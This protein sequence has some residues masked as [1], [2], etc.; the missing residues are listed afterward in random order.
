ME[1]TGSL[2]AGAFTTDTVVTVTVGSDS[3]P[4][5]EGDDYATVAALQFT[6]AAGATSGQTTFTLTPVDDAIS[7][8]TEDIQVTGTAS[9]LGVSPTALQ[10]HDNDTAST[11]L[12][13]SLLPERVSE[14]LPEDITVTAT[15]DAGALDAD[16]AIEL[17]VGG[18]SDTGLPGEDYEAVSEWTLTILA[19][20]TSASTVFR[21]IPVDNQVADEART[22]SVI[23]STTVATLSVVP[24]DGAIITLDDDDNPGVSVSPPLLDVRES[25]SSSYFVSLLTRPTADVTVD[26]DGVL[27]DLGDLGINRTSLVFT[28]AD[29]FVR[30]E[31]IV[32][33]ADDDDSI[34]DEPVTL[35]HAASGPP[36]YENLVA[37]L[38]VTILENDPALVFS[39]TSLS[40]AEGGAAEYSVALVTE[41]TEDVTVTISGASGDVTVQPETLEFTQATW[42]V[43]Q[44][45]T[46]E[47][48]E[49]DDTS[50]DAVT[51]THAAAGGDYDT[52]VGEVRVSV[53]DNDASS[54]SIG[55]GSSG[56]GGGGG[57]GGAETI[58]PVVVREILDQV[59]DVGAVAEVD[60]TPNF[61]DAPSE[62][63]TTV[64]VADPSVATV[65]VD[66]QGVVRIEGLRRGVTEVTVTVTVTVTAGDDATAS[67]TF[68]VTVRSP[69]FVGLVP[70]AADPMRQ[71]FVRVINHSDADGEVTIEAIDDAGM[72]YDP[73]T[74]HLDA[75]ETQ[76]FNSD[77]LEDGNA[78]KGL[79]EGTGLGHGDW[80]LSLDSTLDIEV[81]AYIRTA[82]GLL[83]AM[84][85]TVPVA[86]GAHQVAIFNPGSNPD[87]VSLLR[88][89]NP[90]EAEARVSMT[91]TDDAGASPGTAVEVDIPAAESRTLSAVDLESGAGVVGR[92]GDGHGKWRLEVTSSEPVVAMSLLSSP[93]GHLTN[94]STVPA[95][96][97]GDDHVVALFPSAA[98]PLGRQGFVRVVNRS[99]HDA[100]VE[101]NAYDD[102]EWLYESMMLSLG[103]EETQHFN[104]NDLELGNADKGLSGSTGAGVGDWR[105]VLSSEADIDVL[106][107]IRS[108]DGFLTSMH[109]AAPR[110]EN[111]HRVAIFN[112][113]SNPNQV[114]I[115]RLVNP[116]SEDASV[117]ITGTD[118]A[119]ASPDASVRLTVPAGGSRTIQAPEM[120]SGEGLV[121][122]LGDGAGK[123]RL[124]VEADQPIVVMS[125]LASPTGHLT[126]LSS[127]Q[128]R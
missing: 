46:V 124:S 113:G 74:L 82:D 111:T 58:A 56:G 106:A 10:L 5:T 20:E 78:A 21:L 63:S 103:T 73:V 8:G 87:Q 91:A 61:S 108:A 116:G 12:M 4:A 88:L 99:P 102:S 39:E 33:A 18:A 101:I 16:T 115:L 45:V 125:L 109:D 15:L 121:G 24:A 122:G 59:L 26:I 47:A 31:V 51:L 72:S 94:L 76:H 19:G 17:R 66:A 28:Q 97:D 90:G 49:D 107:Y 100:L 30:Q 85:D 62:G 50:T 89:I 6:V 48:A 81:L 105:L 92:F 110:L 127:A 104:S 35:V 54:G 96:P 93:T 40:V 3:D 120:E 13:L 43:P 84:H 14:N 79:P 36:E 7:E 117:T 22:V 70:R 2:D 80:R 64:T 52:I 37:E 95:M 86:D 11:V 44:T 38:V 29:Y 69:A 77:D 118:D 71:G 27:G 123:W 25:E 60:I 41:P 126:N 67:D 55:G 53:T 119:G 65:S 98:D 83:T 57:G 1:V 128:P 75:A 23:G 68:L 114:S 9:G 112:P 32:T 34:L 42:D